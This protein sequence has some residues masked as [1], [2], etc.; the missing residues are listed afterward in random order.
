MKSMLFSALVIFALASTGCAIQQ[1]AGGCSDGLCGTPTAGCDDCTVLSGDCN[2]SAPRGLTP[3]CSLVRKFGDERGMGLRVNQRGTACNQGRNNG[4]FSR[5]KNQ[6][7]APAAS[8]GC[9][10]CGVADAGGCGCGTA[11]ASDCGCGGAGDCGCGSTSGATIVSLSDGACGC[12]DDACAAGMEVAADSSAVGGLLGKIG[13]QGCDCKL[14]SCLLGGKGKART[15]AAVAGSQVGGCSVPGCG[16]GG[17]YCGGCLSKLRGAHRH[18]YGGT[19]PHTAQAPGN[20]TGMAPSYAYPYYTTRGP[21]DFLMKNP[22]S[23]GY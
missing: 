13:T 11:P 23:I 16:V 17:N 10:T 9:D 8:M 18:P 3:S 6:S 20:G 14:G 2:C 7:V 22:P 19:I 12:G 21:R 5:M 1:G 4:L 15:V